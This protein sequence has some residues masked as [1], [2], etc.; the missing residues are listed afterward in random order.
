VIRAVHDLVYAHDADRARALFRDTAGWP[1]VDAHGGWLIR[2]PIED[3]SF[4]R[5]SI[6]DVPG[7]GQ[8]TIY[9]PRHLF[10]HDL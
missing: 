10:A 8:M 4:G 7:A 3:T 6:M 5:I 2:G 1:Y 9:E